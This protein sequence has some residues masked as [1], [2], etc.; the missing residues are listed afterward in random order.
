MRSEE[1]IKSVRRGLKKSYKMLALFF[2]ISSNL[3]V[4]EIF[5]GK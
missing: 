3:N 5:G 2:M 4:F 1:I